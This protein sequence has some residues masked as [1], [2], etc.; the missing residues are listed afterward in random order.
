MLNA[1]KDHKVG[2]AVIIGVVNK[3]GPQ[4]ADLNVKKV[5]TTFKNLNYATWVIK[6]PTPTIMDTVIKIVSEFNY[7][8]IELKVVMLYYTG[9][10]GSI[11]NN[12]YILLPSDNDKN[13]PYLIDQRVLSPFK[14]C[15]PNCHLDDRKR[16]FLFDCCLKED[17]YAIETLPTT[18][19]RQF[20]P[21]LP[22]Y[23]PPNDYII[24]AFSADYREVCCG[25][26][27]EGGVWTFTLCDNIN[28]HAA[29]MEMIDILIKTRDDVF[30]KAE[31][32][33]DNRGDFFGM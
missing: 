31:I 25:Y 9:Y 6:N 29:D 33:I 23:Q 8:S 18:A 10:G 17:T 13:E 21:Y 22:C 2:L 30:G 24:V 27:S 19:P 11:H 28:Q 1:T 32:V 15:N 5:K 3:K 14:P 26:F 4:G 16:L 12:A 20:Y 7:Y